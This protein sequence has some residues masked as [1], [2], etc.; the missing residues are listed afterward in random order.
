[1][2]DIR[3]A[4]RT[5]ADPVR[6]EGAAR[7]FKTAPGQYGAGDK[8]LGITVPVLRKIARANRG[9]STAEVLKL[10]RS[11]WHEERLVALLILVDAH[12]HAEPKRRLE[13]HRAYLA[14]TEYVNNWDLVDTSAEELVGT[15]IATKGTRMLARLARSKSLWERRIAIIATFSTIKGGNFQ[16]TI[17][18]AE[19]LLND[20]HDLIHKAVGWMIREIGNR[21]IAVERDFLDRHASAMPRTALRYAIEKFSDKERR[22]YMLMRVTP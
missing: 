19:Q 4:I 3:D 13:L 6:A 1:V 11:P 12:R 18:V 17:L 22:H 15:H 9:L 16:P 5:A 20:D 10:L 7:F 8:F 21:N 14:N 2:G